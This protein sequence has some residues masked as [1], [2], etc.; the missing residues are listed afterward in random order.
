[1]FTNPFKAKIRELYASGKSIREIATLLNIT[2][3]TVQRVVRI[4]IARIV[5][6]PYIRKFEERLLRT[7]VCR[8]CGYLVCNPCVVCA[9]RKENRIK[10]ITRP[11]YNDNYILSIVYPKFANLDPHTA[12]AED[13][14]DDNYCRNSEYYDEPDTGDSGINEDRR[15]G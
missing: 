14:W 2:R 10:T 4:R 6:Q 13:I 3:K 9:Y 11:K 12:E 5:G 1:M 7:R 8:K 15:A